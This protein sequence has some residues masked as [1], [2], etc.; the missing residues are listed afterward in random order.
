MTYG[1]VLHSSYALFSPTKT[2]LPTPD[3]VLT[4]PIALRR[5]HAAPGTDIVYG[6]TKA[7]PTLVEC[8]AAAGGGR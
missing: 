6:P 7:V 4:C 2:Y 8:V 3:P 1:I 5:P